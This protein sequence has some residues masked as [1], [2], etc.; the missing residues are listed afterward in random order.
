M[1]QANRQVN[2]IFW[3]AALALAGPAS[4]LHAQTTAPAAPKGF[5]FHDG[6]RAMILGDSITEQKAYSTMIE[7]YVL[8]RYP[9]WNITFRNTGWSGDTMGLRTRGGLDAGFKRDLAP[10]NPTAVTIDFGMNDAR[11]GEGGYEPYLANARTLAGKFKALGTRVIFVS[12][13]PEEKYEAGAPAGSAYNNL[14]LKYSDGLKGVAAKTSNAYIDQIRPMI[15]TIEAGRRAKILGDSGD[16]RL[17]PGGVHPNWGGQLVMA[18]NIL[19][20][21][22][23]TSLVSNVEIDAANTTNYTVKTENAKVTAHPLAIRALPG[24]AV[25]TPPIEF[26]R[27]DGALPW[28]VLTSPE[29]ALVQTIPSFTPM[30]DLSR[31]E[32]KITHLTAPNYEVRCDN[33]PVGTWTKEDLAAGV[34]LSRAP[35][36]VQNQAQ[37]LLQ[38]ILQKNVLFYNR[39]RSVQVYALPTWL[40]TPDN[41]A[42]RSK[43]ITRLDAQIADA[44]K[45]INTLRQPIVHTWTVTPL[46]VAGA[47]APMTATAVPAPA[48]P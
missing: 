27:L 36:P 15:Q 34:N 42:A 5:F 41:E 39:W 38:K 33:V 37:Q 4:Q 45:E 26:E 47:A 6:D 23:A 24:A 7:S 3:L 20:G 17:I 1:K 40:Q 44:E 21:L 32:L 11:A 18:T 48:A 31:Y 35:G 43:E 46:P 19:K 9:T 14:L 22:G 29:T 2:G 28:P 13:S 25:T 16:P 10:L 8:S 30:D 12:P